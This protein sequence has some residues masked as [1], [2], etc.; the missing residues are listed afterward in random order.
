TYHRGLLDAAGIGVLAIVPGARPTELADDDAFARKSLA[1]LV[2]DDE[3]L[4]DGGLIRESF[5]V[6]N[7]MGEDDVDRRGKLR[8]LDPNVPVLGGRDRNRALALDPLNESDQGVDGPFPAKNRLIADN[9]TG[10]V[11]ILLGNADRRPDLPLVS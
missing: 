6:R 10:D 3:G 9:E 2:V 5:P 1:E 4:V 7:D 8:M 11:A